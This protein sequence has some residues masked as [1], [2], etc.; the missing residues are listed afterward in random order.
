MSL[1]NVKIK[2][3]V[4]TSGD[5]ESVMLTSQNFN[6]LLERVGKE[7]DKSAF[8]ELFNHF[9]PRLKSFLMKG[10]ASPAHAEELTQETMLTIWDKA[11][12]YNKE[13]SAASTWIFT[14]AR[15]KRIDA[16]RKIKYHTN[17]PTG[18]LE[19]IQDDIN[20]SPEG[21]L[22]DK[23]THFR[24]DEAIRALPPEQAEL[25]RMSFFDDMPHADIAQK[26]KLPLGTVKS[27]IRLALDRLRKLTNPA[28][29][30]RS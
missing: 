19:S 28:D 22:A 5:A 3:P 26:T 7:R 24:M 4:N 23:V 14:I 8:I 18:G 20:Q 30:G 16:L 11:I 17:D 25:I 13:T 15:N 6:E 2:I 29:Y 1:K 27:R 9:A 12:S 21:M 10:G